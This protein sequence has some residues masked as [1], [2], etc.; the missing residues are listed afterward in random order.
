MRYRKLKLAIW[1]SLLMVPV[2][3]FAQMI[4]K[5][6]QNN[7]VMTM[8]KEGKLGILATGP[9]T[10]LHIF[11]PQNFD[12]SSTQMGQDNIQLVGG[13]EQISGLFGPSIGFG[14]AYTDAANSNRRRAAIAAVQTGETNQIGLSF[15]THPTNVETDNLQEA[16]RLNH[17]GYLGIGT[18]NPQRVLH[19]L[20]TVRMEDL[21]PSTTLTS[22]LVQNPLNADLNTRTLP[23]NSWDGDNQALGVS[24]GSATSSNITLTDGG[25]ISLVAGANVTL[26]EDVTQKT[27]TIAA[28]GGSGG[29]TGSGVATQVAFWSGTTSLASNSNLYWDNTNSRLGVGT[30]T[31]QQPLHTV[32]NVRL[33]NLPASTTLTSVIVQN[34][35][36]K[37][38]YT[39]S[40]PTNSWDGDNQTL[41]VASQ[42]ATAKNITLTDGEQVT[43]IAGT[44]ISL[45][46]N[47]TNKSI[48]INAAS[49]GVTGSGVATRVAFW[50]G[51]TA[52]GSNSN[53]YWNN[54]NSRLGIGTASPARTLDV[55]TAEANWAAFFQNTNGSPSNAPKVALAHSDGRGALIDAG[56]N[57]TATDRVFHVVGGNP[58]Q[59]YL[60][61][62][63]DGTVMINTPSPTTGYILDV[64]GSTYIRNNARVDGHI[65][66]NSANINSRLYVNGH[67]TTTLP[68]GDA[69][70]GTNTSSIHAFSNITTATPSH[71]AIQG[72][73]KSLQ[74]F[75]PSGEVARIAVHGALLDYSSTKWAAAGG[76]GYSWDKNDG[77]CGVAGSIN[78]G[79]SFPNGATVIAGGAFDNPNIG[80]NQFGLHVESDKSY[81]GGKLGVGYSNKNPTE[82]LDVLGNAKVSGTLSVGSTATINDLTLTNLPVE[83]GTRYDVRISSTGVMMRGPQVVSSARYKTD[84]EPLQDDFSKILAVEPKSYRYKEDNVQDI[85]LIAEELDQLGLQNLVQ[86]DEQGRPDAVKYDRVS[87]YLLQVIKQMQARINKLELQ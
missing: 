1:T 2:M 18:T 78:S 86:Y 63:G 32:G 14:Q 21:D 52:L 40:L 67:E 31:P 60:E 61:I 48:T 26:S 5:D 72:S 59:N 69:P 34:P 10:Q 3:G 6:S 79:V 80:T 11:R 49:S 35:T 12:L 46:E 87:L 45:A 81:I 41:G 42:S 28:S 4:V 55:E 22:V 71:W 77:F 20:G 37:D 76:L 25:Q 57:A 70:P 47:V 39:R 75:T 30:A 84:I 56:S 17:L 82:V 58:A 27:I 24:A 29:L 65:S 8:T 9:T 15:F 68:F 54:S 38:L 53:L 51:T 33:E 66:V 19:T 16:V 62:R 13:G 36:S 23:A 73:S 74:T 64:N 7:P 43:L 50:T 85:G 83:S 44:N